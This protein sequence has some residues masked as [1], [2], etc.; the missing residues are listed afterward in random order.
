MTNTLAAIAAENG[1]NY[2]TPE[3]VAEAINRA[4][5]IDRVRLDLLEILGKQ[6]NYGVEDHSLCAFVAWH[7]PRAIQEKT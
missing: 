7:G 6:T 2:I 4:T 1:R 3:D 5:P